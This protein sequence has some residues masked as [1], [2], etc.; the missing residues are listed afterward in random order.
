MS[1]KNIKIIL[2]SFCLSLLFLNTTLILNLYEKFYLH[3]LTVEYEII[4]CYKK[5]NII[6]TKIE[7]TNNTINTAYDKII[8]R[9]YVDADWYML[10]YTDKRR[11]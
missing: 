1:R 3:D 7:A 6:E 9:L 4:K 10:N 2:L 11:R 5:F 8:D